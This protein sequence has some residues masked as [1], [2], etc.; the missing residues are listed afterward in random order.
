MFKVLQLNPNGIGNKLTEQGV[1]MENNKVKVAVIQE[2]KLTSKS[3]NPCIL[4]YTTVHKDRPHGQG[5]GLLIFIQRSV[6]F[7]KQTCCCCRPHLSTEKWWRGPT[8]V[9]MHTG[10]WYPPSNR[11]DWWPPS[12][13]PAGAPSPWGP[14]TN[15]CPVV[16]CLYV[17]AVEQV[18]CCVWF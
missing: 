11:V 18:C 3:K 14:S 7:S 1:V 12:I 8:T 5:G 15:P 16:V 4:N 10:R 13:Q 2:S 6:T 9:S 17:G